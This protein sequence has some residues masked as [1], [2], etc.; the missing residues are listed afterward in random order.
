MTLLTG[1]GTELNPRLLRIHKIEQLAIK[2]IKNSMFGGILKSSKHIFKR[3]TYSSISFG[4]LK[5]FFGE[6]EGN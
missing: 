4:H 6:L 3:V 5:I 1:F 2:K